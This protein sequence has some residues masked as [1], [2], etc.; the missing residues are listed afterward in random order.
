MLQAAL[1][2]NL[3]SLIRVM[4]LVNYLWY[5]RKA[6]TPKEKLKATEALYY[7]YEYEYPYI[8]S[9]LAIGITYSVFCPVILGNLLAST[10]N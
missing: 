2:T 10:N 6:V 5:I 9:Y 3:A 4:S 8:I 7:S 1:L